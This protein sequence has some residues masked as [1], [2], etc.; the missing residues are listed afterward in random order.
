MERHSRRGQ[1]AVRAPRK[2]ARHVPGQRAAGGR[3]CDRASTNTLGT[4]A[5]GIHQDHGQF[6][7]QVSL[8]DLEPT[9]VRVEPY[10]GGI[11]GGAPLRQEMQRVRRQL[12]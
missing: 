4:R 12:R 1:P 2:R 8:A 11:H 5:G 3:G 9:A 10:A 6:D 7:V